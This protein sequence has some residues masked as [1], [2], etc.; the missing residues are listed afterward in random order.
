MVYD[1]LRKDEDLWMGVD[2]IIP[3]PLHRRRR[4]E[5]GFN[6][7]EVVAREIGKRAGITLARNVLRKIRNSPPQTTLEREERAE[8]VREAFAVVRKE[9]LRG[10][11]ILLVDDVYTTGSTMGECAR[12]LLQEGAAEVRAITV[13]QA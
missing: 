3:V 2:L 9:F 8:N 11:V 1:T 12:I 13:A 7:A 5:R 10:K 4:W 6:Q